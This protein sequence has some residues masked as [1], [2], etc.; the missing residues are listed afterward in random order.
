M[1]SSDLLG[2]DEDLFT[3][4]AAGANGFAHASLVAVDKSGIDVTIADIDGVVDMLNQFFVV[5]NLPGSEADARNFDVVCK[6]KAAGN[7]GQNK[8]PKVFL[9]G[10]LSI[11]AGKGKASK[12]ADVFLFVALYQ[13]A[14]VNLKTKKKWIQRLSKNEKVV[15]RIVPA[16]RP[17]IRTKSNVSRAFAVGGMGTERTTIQA[18]KLFFRI[19]KD[20]AR[21]IRCFPSFNGRRARGAG[22]CPAPTE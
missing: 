10:P 19:A 22:I 20:A 15:V 3:R 2:C 7:G 1:C 16:Q 11:E 13:G 14:F 8:S 21:T 17:L 12:A 4:N 6:T 9:N 5:G 18:R